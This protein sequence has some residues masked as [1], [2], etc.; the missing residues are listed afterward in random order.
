MQA[1]RTA[2]RSAPVAL[3][4]SSSSALLAHDNVVLTAPSPDANVSAHR[5]FPAFG[6]SQNVYTVPSGRTFVLTDVIASGA[7]SIQ[8]GGQIRFRPRSGEHMAFESGLRFTSGSTLVLVPSLSGASGSIT[9][10]GYLY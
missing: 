2:A 8:V 3:L 10:S 4:L 9:I 6:G 7:F 1:L 5:D